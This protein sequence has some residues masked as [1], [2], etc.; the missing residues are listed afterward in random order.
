MKKHKIGFLIEL[1]TC[2]W[3]FYVL[4]VKRTKHIEPNNHLIVT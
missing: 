1:V 3:F 4:S 2:I